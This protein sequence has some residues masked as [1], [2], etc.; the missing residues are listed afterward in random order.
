[1]TRIAGAF[2]DRIVTILGPNDTYVGALI[3]R[4]LRQ[5]GLHYVFRPEF[6]HIDMVVPGPVILIDQEWELFVDLFLDSIR[7]ASHPHGIKDHQ[8]VLLVKLASDDW[9]CCS[10]DQDLSLAGG[11]EDEAV[12]SGWLQKWLPQ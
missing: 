2:H 11:P 9:F 7:D 12:L 5:L 8:P 6:E 1:M 10:T 4:V 3:E